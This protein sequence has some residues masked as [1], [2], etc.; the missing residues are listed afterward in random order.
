MQFFLK[1]IIY[2][3]YYSSRGM[4]ILADIPQSQNLKRRR[5]NVI[6]IK[7]CKINSIFDKLIPQWA[8]L[9]LPCLRRAKMDATSTTSY[10]DLWTSPKFNG[11]EKIWF[12]SLSLHPFTS[13]A[14]EYKYYFGASAQFSHKKTFS[15]LFPL[16]KK[17]WRNFKTNWG[18]DQAAVPPGPGAQLQTQRV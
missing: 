2:V 17:Y 13:L 5:P 15:L 14:S 9:F 11:M 12:L 18:I 10:Q 7:N 3:T 4:K 6:R 1:W 16:F 8:V